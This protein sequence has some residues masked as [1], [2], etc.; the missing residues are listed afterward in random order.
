MPPH[1]LETAAEFTLPMTFE[2]LGPQKSISVY[3]YSLLRNIYQRI[4]IPLLQ[5]Q[6]GASYYL[7]TNHEFKF[8]PYI[9]IWPDL[10]RSPTKHFSNF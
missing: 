10:I 5:P 8:N 6:V 7:F 4:S 1:E 9:D 3:T 2:I